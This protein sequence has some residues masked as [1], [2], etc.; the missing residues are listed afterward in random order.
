[1]FDAHRIAPRLSRI[2]AT[3]RACAVAC[4]ALAAASLP[5]RIAAQDAP[6]RPALAAGADTADWEAYYDYAVV[7]LRRS[8]EKA[9]DGFYWAA[10]LDPSRPEPLYGQ[11]V[12]FWVPRLDQFVR[13]LDDDRAIVQSPMAR[14]ADSLRYSAQ[15][16]NPFVHQGLL[17][18]LFDMLPGIWGD[19]AIT[20]AW[21]AYANGHRSAAERFAL[22]VRQ[23]K[24]RVWLREDYARALAVNGD[25]AG[26]SSELTTV[27]SSLRLEDERRVVRVYQSKAMLEY[28]IALLHVARGDTSAAEESLGRAL[29]EDVAFH[30]AHVV[31]A[32]LALASGDTATAITEYALAVDIAPDNVVARMGHGAAL[33]AAGRP[34]EAAVAFEAAIG[35]EPYYADARLNLAIAHE[36]S[37][38]LARAV[39]AYEDYLERAPRRAIEGVTLARAR[40]AAVSAAYLRQQSTGARTAPASPT[41][42]AQSLAP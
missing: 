34:R 37:G 17:L 20:R 33:I 14:A 41:S 24:R 27:L 19:D 6:P 18:V 26:A 31:L 39:Y 28:S 25:F 10:R 9:G 32:T 40:H 15:V 3:A 12:A 16:R 8:G 38:D 29:V 36:G 23:N 35:L 7:Q 1:M 11:W 13:Y 21:L 5:Q 30:P 22:A 4:V 42:P 2:S